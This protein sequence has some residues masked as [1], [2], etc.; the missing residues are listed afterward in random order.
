MGD[1]EAVLRPRRRAPGADAGAGAGA[2][3][4]DRAIRPELVAA[5]LQRQRLLVRA[6]AQ[7]GRLQALGDEAL[8]RPGVD[9]GAHRLRLGGALGV[10]LGDV[11]A[12]D[13]D[14]LGEPGPVLPAP[15]FQ[16]LGVGRAVAQVGGEVEQRLLDEPRHHAGVGAAAVHRRGTLARV[17][18]LEVEHG[19]AQ[20]VVRA[21][22]HG[23]R[24]VGVEARPGLGDRVDVERADLVGEPHHRHRGDFDREIDDERLAATLRQ[25]RAQQRIDVVFS[26]LVLDESNI[27]LV[28]QAAI[29][30]DRVDHGEALGIVAEVPLD[31]RQRAPPDGAEPD[32]HD[33]PR[34][35]PVHRPVGHASR[36]PWNVSHRLPARERPCGGI[37]CRDQVTAVR[38][39]RQAV[40]RE[41]EG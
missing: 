8:D 20:R 23:E 18:A 31:Q 10:A 11:D 3:Q 13:A 6:P 37:P 16:R 32:H 36:L 35:R 34:D 27:A 41:R 28:E 40:R 19:L 22:R 1:E 9:E 12:L 30:V 38:R 14:G 29:G 2:H 24:G 15:I 26:H 21:L 17:L 33:G 39:G 7:L 25:Q 5:A 4:V